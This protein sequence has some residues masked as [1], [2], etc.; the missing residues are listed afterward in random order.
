MSTKKPRA[1]TGRLRFSEEECSAAGMHEPNRLNPLNNAGSVIADVT[2]RQLSEAEEENL[3]L[4]AAHQSEQA[5]EN[6]ARTVQSIHRSKKVKQHRKARLENPSLSSNPLSRWRQRQAIRKAYSNKSGGAGRSTAETATLALRKSRDLAEKALALLARNKRILMVL[7]GIALLLLFVMTVFTSCSQM[8]LGGL[9]ALVST[10]YTAEDR[11]ICDAD[12][13]LTRLEA[14]LDYEIQNV[15]RTHPGYDEYRYA[16]DPIGHDPHELMAYL[17]ARYMDFTYPQVRGDIQTLFNAMYTLSITETVEVRYRTEIRTR[18]VTTHDPVTGESDTYEET[19]EVQVPYNYYILNTRLTSRSLYTMAYPRLTPEQQEM[20]T[21]YMETKGNKQYF[22]NP[23]PFNWQGSVSSLYGW[24]VDPI[25]KELQLHRGLDLA[26]SDGTSI[27]SI[28]DGTVL[29]VGYDSGYGNYVVV[30]DKEGYRSTY[31]HCQSI[32]V[33]TGQTVQRGST[34]A[35]VGHS[36]RS[37]RSHMHLELSHNGEYLNPYFFIEGT[38]PY[39]PP[40]STGPYTRYDIPPEALADPAFSALMVEAQKYLGYPYVWGGST[41]QTSFDCS[42]FVS[43]VFS[44]SGGYPL[45]RTTAQGIFDQCAVVPPAEVRPGDIVFFTGTYDSPGPVS[46]VGI[47]V[48]NGMMI[49]CGDPIQYAS[50]ETAYWRQH[51][52]AFGRL[53]GR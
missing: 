26:A 19:Y 37:T 1:P 31:A 50:I 8:A 10:S 43:W 29:S 38:N 45:S 5:V 16:V 51:F 44:H 9:N 23:F 40:A 27:R 18:T 47:Y 6:T 36:G 32:A 21:V 49:H 53:T 34:I 20:Y 42:G 25:T 3:G 4:E 30:Q 13:E 52:Y 17:T 15:E 39:T 41:P 11:D 46:H 7:A 22:A 12:L 24:R 48:G 14:N 28:M 33:R 2:H 35:T